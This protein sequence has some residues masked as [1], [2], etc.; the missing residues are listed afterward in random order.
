[1]SDEEL[2][3]GWTVATLDD[4]ARWSSGGTPKAGTAAYYGGH[5]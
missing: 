5:R 4:V 2:P 3:K 1:M